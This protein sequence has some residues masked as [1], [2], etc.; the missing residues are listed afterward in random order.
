MWVWGGLAISSGVLGRDI[1]PPSFCGVSEAIEA[2]ILRERTL[3][4]D[5]E[6]SRGF[7]TVGT[8]V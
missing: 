4:E 6:R 8:A 1:F 2:K 3:K 7:S 5:R